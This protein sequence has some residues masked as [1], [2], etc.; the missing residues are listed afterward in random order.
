MAFDLRQINESNFLWMQGRIKPDPEGEREQ[1]GREAMKRGNSR[2]VLVAPVE[3]QEGVGFA[4]EIL[5]VQLVSTELHH[6]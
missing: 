2:A 4:K 1:R 6:H 5:F 3:D